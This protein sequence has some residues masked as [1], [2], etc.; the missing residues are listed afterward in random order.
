MD[1]GA[2]AGPASAE[3][4]GGGRAGLPRAEPEQESAEPG[5]AGPNLTPSGSARVKGEIVMDPIAIP[6][7][8]A[9]AP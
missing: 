8:T 4:G 7:T 2:F 3:R 6:I 1:G 5:A 9:M